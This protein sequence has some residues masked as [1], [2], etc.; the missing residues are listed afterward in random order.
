MQYCISDYSV[1]LSHIKIHH[2]AV[3]VVI[4][5]ASHYIQISNINL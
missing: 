1:G 5:Y 3:A 4:M 2:L